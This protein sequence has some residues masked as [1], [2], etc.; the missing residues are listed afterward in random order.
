MKFEME[1]WKL[2]LLYIC[3]DGT[4]GHGKGPIAAKDSV[5]AG[6]I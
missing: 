1:E 2:K 6:L 3:M 5:T 4:L